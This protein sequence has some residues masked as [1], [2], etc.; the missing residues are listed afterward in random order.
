MAR[1]APL[2]HHRH[3]FLPLIQLGADRGSLQLH[4]SR[5]GTGGLVSLFKEIFA[6]GLA[7]HDLLGPGETRHGEDLSRI[8]A[9]V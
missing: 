5:S 8:A 3:L 2:P 9:V 7:H 4:I 6:V 1:I